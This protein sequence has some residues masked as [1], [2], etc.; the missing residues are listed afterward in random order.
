MTTEAAYQYG[1][2]ETKGQVRPGMRADLV[3]LSGDPLAMRPQDLRDIE[4]HATYKDGEA[5]FTA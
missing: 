2:E 4:V 5:V 3:I 1:E